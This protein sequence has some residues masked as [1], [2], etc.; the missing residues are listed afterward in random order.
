MKSKTIKAT[1]VEPDRVGV[2]DGN[3]PSG[4]SAGNGSS[5][6]HEP[7]VDTTVVHARSSEVRLRCGVVLLVELEHDGIARLSGN[8][9]RVV[10]K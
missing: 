4:E 3:I 5:N 10:S 9:R 6:G 1:Y 2:V 7:R 8:E